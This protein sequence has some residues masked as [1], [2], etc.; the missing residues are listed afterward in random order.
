MPQNQE[1]KQKK[2]NKRLTTQ[3]RLLSPSKKRFFSIQIL[4]RLTFHFQGRKVTPILQALQG[5][6]ILFAV[7]FF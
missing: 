3:K 5:Q 1:N 6:F 7:R 4:F 2:H